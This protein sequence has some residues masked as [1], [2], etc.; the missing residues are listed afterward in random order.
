MSLRPYG[1]NELADSAQCYAHTE[2]LSSAGSSLSCRLGYEVPGLFPQFYL[3]IRTRQTAMPC[4]RE[5]AVQTASSR[6]S[7]QGVVQGTRQ[8]LRVFLPLLWPPN[9]FGLK[10]KRFAPSRCEKKMAAGDLNWSPHARA[11]PPRARRI[12]ASSVWVS[13]YRNQQ[14]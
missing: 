14:C 5:Q 9:H 1:R 11:A 10:A 7:E 6:V 12:F 13:F 8:R 4:G 3:E 2:R